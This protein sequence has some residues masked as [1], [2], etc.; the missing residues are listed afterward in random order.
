[1]GCN[2]YDRLLADGAGHAPNHPYLVDEKPL[3]TCTAGQ[4]LVADIVGKSC[5][6]DRIIGDSL[7]HDIQPGDLIAF[8]GTGAYQEM[9][10]SNFNSMGRPATILVSER[11]TGLIRHR[12]TTED[13]LSREVV[14]NWLKP[15]NSNH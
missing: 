13:V 3:S 1:M 2:R 9:Q 4:R 5:G 10:S 8:V 7:P 6:P 15:A 11:R 14:P 12:E